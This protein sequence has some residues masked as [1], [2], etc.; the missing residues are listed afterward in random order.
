[1]MITKKQIAIFGGGASGLMV[2]DVL[3]KTCNVTIYEKEKTI[4]QKLLVAGKGGFNFT[5]EIPTEEM[6]NK[7]SPSR[8]FSN[9]IQKF[10]STD[11][12]N[13]LADLGIPTYVGT[14]KR[15]FPKDGI[16]PIQVVDAIKKKLL[17]NNV[18]FLTIHKFI[19]F[20]KSTKPIVEYNNEQKIIDADYYIFALGGAS[21]KITGSD[22]KWE[23]M[24]NSIGIST[25]PFQS[26]NCGVNIN[27]SDNIKIHSG[28]PLKNIRISIGNL[29]SKGEA[30]ITDYG[31]EGN[32]IY[33]IVP[34]VRK[35]ISK[36][37]IANITIDFKPSNT[38]EQLL[39]KSKVKSEKIEEINIKPARQFVGRDGDMSIKTKDYARVFN[40]KS[41]ELALI[42][43]Y[44]SKETYLNVETFIDSLKKIEIS[45]DFLRP[46][47]EA[48]STVGGIDI[49]ELNSDFSLKKHPN[50]FTIGE[51]VNW[52]APTGGFLLQGCF[53]MGD[54]VGRSILKKTFT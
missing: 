35:E 33:S 45:I 28:K 21:W 41:V 37:S 14:S 42:K 7:Y 27:W 39:Q 43:T 36:N 13:W 5:S 4:G 26:S 32:A 31:L 47:D 25:L 46:I 12:R 48:I 15:I 54:F 19:S 44:T 24:F 23:S 8:I 6:I 53:S 16:K 52:D 49:N 10:N 40:L 30:V 20:D 18:Q 3:S 22:G 1:M 17:A 51:M 34:E 29:L 2:A 50:I 38:A 11:L 9:P